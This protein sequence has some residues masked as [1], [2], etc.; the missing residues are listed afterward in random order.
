MNP[1]EIPPGS[2]K[3]LGL[4][5]RASLDQGLAVLVA[6]VLHK[7]LDEAG[8]QI[9][10][11]GL[12]LGGVGVGVAGIQDARIHA[13]Q[14]GRHGQVEVRDGLG[15]GLQDGAVKDRVDDAAGV[16]DGNALAGAVPAGV[17]QVG[18]DSCAGYVRW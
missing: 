12:P 3:C 1:A 15:L 10:R 6:S 16:L 4:E 7:V 14:C 13:R 2:R 17:D 8:R 18:L 9:L 5:L 11:L